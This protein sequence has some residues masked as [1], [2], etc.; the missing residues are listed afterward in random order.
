MAEKTKAI[1]VEDG[2]SVASQRSASLPGP[3]GKGT[4]TTQLPSTVR[5]PSLGEAEADDFNSAHQDDGRDANNTP[6][7]PTYHFRRRI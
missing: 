2:E 7:P 5:E 6:A 4:G 1:I 3:N